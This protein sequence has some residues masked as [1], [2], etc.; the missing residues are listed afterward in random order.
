MSTP[1]TAVPAALA[2]LFHLPLAPGTRRRLDL[3]LAGLASEAWP[4]DQPFPDRGPAVPAAALHDPA[5]VR[6][7]VERLKDRWGGPLEAVASQWHKHYGAAVLTGPLLA[8]TV[9]GRPL[10]PPLE[11]AVLLLDPGPGEGAGLP[12][13]LV[14]ANRFHAPQDPARPDPRGPADPA[15]PARPTPAEPAR[16]AARAAEQPAA[17]TCAQGAGPLGRCGHPLPAAP[18][19]RQA[20][21]VGPSQLPGD[22]PASRV[23]PPEPAQGI[24]LPRV[25]LP[26][27]K[28]SEKGYQTVPMVARVS[29][30][31]FC[32]S[33]RGRRRHGPPAPPRPP[34][35]GRPGRRC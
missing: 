24:H 29:I 32:L 27:L 34:V 1:A 16:P 30:S 17:A 9:A 28:L 12:A 10:V 14:F 21:P 8:M 20:R 11:N 6:Q 5:L 13:A 15:R 19:S 23:G 31:L 7:L 25:T 3:F 26:S 2:S 4:P 18:G 33:A 35:P 22:G